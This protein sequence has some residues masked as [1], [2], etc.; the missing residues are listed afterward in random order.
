M[1][2]FTS[3]D[4]SPVAALVDKAT[5]ERLTSEDWGHIIEVCDAVNEAPAANGAV[6]LAA[7]CDR[8]GNSNGNV[9]LFALTL[10]NALTQNCDT[11]VYPEVASPAVCD[12]LLRLGTDRNTHRSVKMRLLSI[13][14]D[15]AE[16]AKSNPSL[17]PIR[18]IY[19]KLAPSDKKQSPERGAEDDVELQRAIKESLNIGSKSMPAAPHR[20]TSKPAVQTVRALYSLVGG[21]PG[22]LS[23]EKGDVIEVLDDKH[24]DWWR[25]MLNGQVG[26]FPVNYV[27]P[28]DNSAGSS[29]SQAQAPTSQD[30]VFILAQAR[31]VEKLLSIFATASR[32]PE[33]SILD[34]KDVQ[35]MY[36]E[37]IAIR[38]RLIQLID[39]YSTKKQD[40]LNL[41]TKLINARR[42]YDNLM[43][44]EI[45]SRNSPNVYSEHM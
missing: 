29:N 10:L 23:F 42:T 35:T 36:N 33:Y 2:F 18:D 7:V 13:L 5:D 20:P 24:K 19:L 41:S 21:E 16:L 25:G 45:S 44:A 1:G 30:E 40:L 37:L 39:E 31:N 34:N 12:A 27:E 4:K 6:A 17:S 3:N 32:H 11:K 15:T 8:L 38:P 26:V 43:N 28:C 14:E 9:Q 22:E